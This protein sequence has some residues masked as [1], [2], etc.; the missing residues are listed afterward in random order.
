MIMLVPLKTNR[1]MT[2]MSDPQDKI[3]VMEHS[4]AL[5]N[6]QQ[7]YYYRMDLCVNERQHI[8]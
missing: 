4:P 5:T 3:L 6:E 7:Q 8:V 2:N 1:F